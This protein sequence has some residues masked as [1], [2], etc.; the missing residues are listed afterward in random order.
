[1]GGK[2][3]GVWGGS[4]VK[5]KRR[6]VFGLP[7]DPDDRFFVQAF[8]QISIRLP[9][10]TGKRIGFF[11]GVRGTVDVDGTGECIFDPRIRALYGLRFPFTGVF[12]AIYLQ[13]NVHFYTLF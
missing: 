13:K 2:T 12:F 3:G 7:R 4:T 10:L 9:P 11:L 6:P 8:H 5:V 1:L